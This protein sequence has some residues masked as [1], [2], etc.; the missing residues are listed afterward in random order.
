MKPSIEKCFEL[1]D[2]GFSLISCSET[3]A[4]NFP[5]KKSQTKPLDESAFRKNYNYS[6]GIYYKNGDEIPPTNAVGI[7]CGYGDLEVIDIDLKVLS[8]AKE[9]KDFWE[10]FISYCEDSIFNFWDK[11]CIT[12]TKNEGFHIL[13][14][15]K[16]A[17]GNLKLAKLKGHKEY[18]IETRGIGGMV[19]YYGNYPKENKVPYSKIDYISDDDREILFDIINYFN[20]EI[21]D[22]EVENKPKE[23]ESEYAEQRLKPWEDFN[24]RNKI[25]DVIKDYFKE[26]RKSEKKTAVKRNGTDKT[27]SGYIYHDKNFLYLHSGNCN[28]LPSE[29]PLSAFACWTYL[30]YHGD[31]SESTKAAYDDGYGDRLPPK[32]IEAKE[33]VIKKQKEALGDYIDFPLDIFPREFQKYILDCVE[34]LDSNADFMGSSLIWALSLMCGNS[35]K[36]RVKQGWVESPII[37]V[38]IVGDRGIGKSHSITNIL[39]PLEKENTQSITRYNKDLEEYNKYEQLSKEEKL[40]VEEV[41]KPSKQQF[42]INDSTIEALIQLHQEN[43]NSIGLFKDELAGWMKDFNKYREGSDMETWISS[44]NGKMIILNRVRSESN[45]FLAHPFIPVIGGIQPD[46]LQNF[47]T[48]DNLNSGFL[49]RLLLSFPKTDK[50]PP[51]NRNQIPADAFTWYENS[52]RVLFRNIKY[53]IELD[54]NNNVIPTIFEWSE[55]ADSEWER[56]FNKISN[57]ENSDK[58]SEYLK[59]MLPKQKIYVPRFALLIHIFRMACDLESKEELLISKESVL[60]AEKLSDYY[61]FMAQKVK[62]GAK[63][64]SEL[65]SIATDSRLSLYDKIKKMHELDNKFNKKEAARLLDVT[66]QTIYNHIKKIEK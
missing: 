5:W 28:G 30:N 17:E 2:R 37:W 16:R 8:T 23:V 57:M 39:Y 56:I 24:A 38:A 14:K 7:V 63:E 18:I 64:S 31:F 51:Y 36:I 4:P 21:N 48:E 32:K 40:R 61:I 58:N 10:L 25:W 12:K 6:G 27:H 42:I 54:E 1:I 34:T 26:G 44:F 22:K 15:T 50:I 55:E 29:T 41:K 65:K 62:I 35:Y 13:Y 47:Y 52:I 59:S 3:K 66:R 60:A 20:Y 19:I 46:I 49:D 33:S 9:K 11:F 53:A 43:K 45:A